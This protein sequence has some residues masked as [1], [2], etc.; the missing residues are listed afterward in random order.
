MHLENWSAQAKMQRRLTE[1]GIAA[2]TV[3]ADFFVDFFVDFLP[4]LFFVGLFL[5]GPFLVAIVF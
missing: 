1:D 4:A 2:A 3:R 5:P